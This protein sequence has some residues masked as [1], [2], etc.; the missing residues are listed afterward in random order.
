MGLPHPSRAQMHSEQCVERT[1]YISSTLPPIPLTTTSSPSRWP[2]QTPSM[3]QLSLKLM[4]CDSPWTISLFWISSPLFSVHSL[5][6][7]HPLLSCKHPQL[8]LLCPLFNTPVKTLTKSKLHCQPFTAYIHSLTLKAKVLTV[9]NKTPGVWP[10]L[11]VFHPLLPSALR[12]LAT[13]SASQEWHC[14]LGSSCLRYLYGWLPRFLQFS[15]QMSPYWKHSP[16]PPYI[17][18]NSLPTLLFFI[19][20]ITWHYMF[21]SFSDYCLYLLFGI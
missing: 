6:S 15:A 5:S 19:V 12:A 18:Q 13:L 17:K 21:I 14:Y 10:L 11:P 2:P 20:Y 1:E 8:A 16:W 3:M 4:R 9:A 7:F